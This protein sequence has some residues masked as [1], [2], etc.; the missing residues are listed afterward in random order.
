MMYL[1]ALPLAY[2][3]SQYFVTSRLPIVGNILFLL[4]LGVCLVVEI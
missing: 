3:Y 1:V 4:L 2:I